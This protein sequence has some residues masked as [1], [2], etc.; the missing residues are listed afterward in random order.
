MSNVI[1]YTTDDGM[2]NIDL[3]LES[4]TVWLWQLELAD[5]FKTSKQNIS[6]HI[7]SIYADQELSVRE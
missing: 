3:H 1:L 7:K 5:L 6:K 2:T 4:D